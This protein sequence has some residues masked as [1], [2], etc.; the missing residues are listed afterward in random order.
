MTVA[1]ATSRQE[2]C[3][4]V[5]HNDEVARKRKD[6]SFLASKDNALGDNLKG[7]GMGV[8]AGMR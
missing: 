4:R 2:Y 8:C 3:C 1:G 5:Q 6:R 7:T